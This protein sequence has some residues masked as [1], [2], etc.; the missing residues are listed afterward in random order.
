MSLGLTPRQSDLF[1]TTTSFCESR[2]PADSIYGLLHRQCFELFPDEM[3]ADLFT[4]VGRRSVPPM[5]VAVVMVLQRLEGCSDRE[6]VDRFAYDLRW[7]YAAGGLD[8]DYPG[9]VHTVLV[10][11]RARLAD[12]EDPDRVFEVTLQAA[13][14]AGLVGRK[15]V[16]DSTA[17][18]DAVATMDTVTLI[19]S[20]IRGVLAVCTSWEDHELR[21]VLTR[22]DDY[23]S[24]GKPSCDW[25]DRQA[26]GELVEA[27]ARDAHA[28][29]AALDGR[30]LA[31]ALQKAGELLATVVG[32]DLETDDEGRFRIARKVAK[33]RVISTVDPEARHGHKTAARGFD[34]YKG[35]VAIDPD[36]EVI[37]ANTVTAGNVGDAAAAE[38][39]LAA[40]TTETAGEPLTVY[41]DSAYGTGALLETFE[42]AGVEARCRT[43]P[44][45]APGGRF[46]KSEF[47]ID[48]DAGTVRCPA[49]HTAPLRPLKVG[50]IARFGG[51]CAACPLVKKCT[52][53]RSGRTIQLGEHERHLANARAR[54]TDPAW[55]TDYTQTR[56]KVERKIGHLMRRKHG[57][58]HARVRGSTK[59]AAD[60]S[61]LAA[62]VNLA[63]FAVLGLDRQPAG[64]AL[65][66]S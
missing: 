48:Q 29:L 33:D 17:L 16:L 52:A 6:A 61:L 34:G 26:R 66:T 43:Q 37:V 13:R 25:E 62:A 47:E 30:E 44:P 3:F 38:T 64:W 9:F 14:E 63:R 27:L 10:D 40:D 4:D 46:P 39:L 22:D 19:R 41:G 57:G 12:S 65:S 2:V 5:I 20:A 28:V 56:P 59:V 36:S 60:F 7:K 18:Y 8:F 23:R 54:Q 53:S 45:R 21:V 55:K 58:R 11:M 50:Q 42:Q 15:R 49:G 35:H 51:V 32:Q 24:A 1:A 31:P